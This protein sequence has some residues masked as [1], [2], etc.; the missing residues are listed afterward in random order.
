MKNGMLAIMLIM[1]VLLAYRIIMINRTERTRVVKD[2]VLLHIIAASTIF[3]YALTLFH[4]K[5]TFAVMA[6]GLY[7][8]SSD[9]LLM[10]FFV[11][12]NAGDF[13]RKKGRNHHSGIYYHRWNFVPDQCI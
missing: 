12:L 8:L 11:Y 3:F 2:V 7:F 5:E 10:F 4:W 6:Y 1:V 13:C 9:F